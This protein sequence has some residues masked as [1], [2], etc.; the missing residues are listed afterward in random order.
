MELNDL[1]LQL[2]EAARNGETAEVEK[3][4]KAGAQVNYY[5]PEMLQAT[6]LHWASTNGHADTVEKLV[7]LGASVFPTNQFGWTA[8]HH[9]ANWG[10]VDCVKA[11]IK[12]GAD[13][14]AKSESGS[15]PI[16]AA[17]FKG[18]LPVVETIRE[19]SDD[20]FADLFKKMDAPQ[21]EGFD[22]SLGGSTKR[23]EVNYSVWQE[24]WGE[25]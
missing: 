4:A 20:E 13:P 5:D 22:G 1:N 7:E 23:G 3:L 16:E 21:I 9:A 11:L 18:Y 15:T 24:S 25:Q 10:Y 17:S 19:M 8:L 12:A 2:F 6:A 14:M